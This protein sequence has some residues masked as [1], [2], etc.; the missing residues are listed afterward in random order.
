MADGEFNGVALAAIGVGVVFAWGAI[1][2]KSPLKALQ[3]TVQGQSPA[4]TPQTQAITAF[5]G[6]S[7]P[8]PIASDAQIASGYGWIDT[9]MQSWGFSRG[10]RAGALGNLQVESGFSPTAGNANEGAIGI[11]QWEGGRRTA[12]QQMAASMGLQETDGNAQLAFMKHELDTSRADVYAYMIAAVDPVSAAAYWDSR[13]EVSAGTTRGE[14]EANA[15]AI[16][17][18]LGSNSGSVGGRTLKAAG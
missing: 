15:K 3:A 8:T 2:G 17:A 7:N 11:A 13:Y 14:R 16:Y 5:G 10:G 18:Q 1:K 4:S 6:N 12:L 9:A